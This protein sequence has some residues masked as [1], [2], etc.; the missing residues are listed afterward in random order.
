MVMG[1]V[2]SYRLASLEETIAQLSRE[3]CQIM[4]GG[5]DLMVQ[6]KSPMG[7]PARFDKPVMFIDHLKELKQIDQVNQDLHIGACCTY[8]EIL[9]HPLIPNIFKVAIK[10]IA[11]PAIRNRGTL[12][13]NICNASPAGD[14]LPL[15]YIFN[16]Q[17]RLRSSKGERVVG[18]QDFILGPRR[19]DRLREEI[20]T[21]IILPEMLADRIVF[22]KVANRRADAIAKISFAG[23]MRL[24][25]GRVGEA[26]FAFGAVGPT[27][28]RSLDIEQKLKGE[29]F[30]LDPKVVDGVVAYFDRIITPID[31]HRSTAAY[32]K[33]VALRL[34]RHFLETM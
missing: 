10:Q 6:H 9:E 5:T 17:I 34:L 29:A 25:G 8:T 22:E 23:S 2:L 1:T 32:R 3:D 14:T 30:P 33:T 21:E 7:A 12:G 15:L 18:I 20:L 31:D 4:A 24:E 11:A 26:R 13:G 27:I 28:V 16:A 19:V